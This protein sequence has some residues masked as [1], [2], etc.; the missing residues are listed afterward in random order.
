MNRGITIVA[1][2]VLSWMIFVVPVLV[3]RHVKH[4][5]PDGLTCCS[6]DLEWRI[7]HVF[8]HRS[9]TDV[10][11]NAQEYRA[12]DTAGACLVRGGSP[13]MDDDIHVYIACL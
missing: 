9:D 12:A 1:L 8:V 4:P 13:L 6:D 5:T 7:Q 11:G 3:L 2:C 10:L